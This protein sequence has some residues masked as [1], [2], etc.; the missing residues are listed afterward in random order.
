[1]SEYLFLKLCG[2]QSQ[3]HV[4][5]MPDIHAQRSSGYWPGLRP[6]H[7]PL[8]S[9]QVIRSAD[10]DG[11]LAAAL[12]LATSSCHIMGTVY[13]ESCQDAI[14]APNP[15]GTRVTVA[16]IHSARIGFLGLG[17]QVQ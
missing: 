15:Q 5:L 2:S 14:S 17:A 8:R 6:G 1:M 11:R 13:T 10:K 7:R 12:G 3:L 16:G 9:S 4:G